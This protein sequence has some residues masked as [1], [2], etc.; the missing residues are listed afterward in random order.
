MSRLDQNLLHDSE[1]TNKQIEPNTLLSLQRHHWPAISK[2][3]IHGYLLSHPT[4]QISE[5]MTSKPR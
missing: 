5:M 4:I 3:Y 2:I 1:L